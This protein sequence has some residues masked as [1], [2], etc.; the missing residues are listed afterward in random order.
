MIFSHALL[1]FAIMFAFAVMDADGKPETDNK[2]VIYQTMWEGDNISGELYV[3]G[4]LM[5]KFS[6]SQ[7]AGGSPLNHLLIG[8]NEIRADVRKTDTSKPALFSFGVSKLTRGDIAA[9]NDRGNLLSGEL[10]DK[11]FNA[12]R[13]LTLS[14]KFESSLDFS[15]HLLAT[16]KAGEKDV[17]EYAKKIYAL[18][19]AKNVKG[20]EKEFAVKISDYSKAF[21]ADNF[22]AEFRSYLTK[23]L[24]KGSLVKIN[25]RNLRAKKTGPGNNIWLVQEGDKELIRFISPNGAA[26]ELEIYIGSVDGALQVIR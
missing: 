4:F 15:R 20:I 24:L 14:K 7:A 17:I 23:E 5:N 10:T 6:G 13:T 25:T 11:D 21:S 26:T 18:F 8:K 3:N 9:T 1:F 19:K 2:N 12:S 22:A 16:G